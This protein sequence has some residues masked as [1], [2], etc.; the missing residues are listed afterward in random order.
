[1]AER[2]AKGLCFNCDELFTPTHVCRSVLFY[3]TP[4]MDGDDQEDEPLEKEDLVEVTRG[5]REAVK[6][7]PGVG[8]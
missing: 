7:I 4:V 3:F 6:G 2:R 1:M 8:A 5:H